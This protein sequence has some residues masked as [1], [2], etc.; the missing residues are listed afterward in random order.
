MKHVTP[1]FIAFLLAG[2]AGS[3]VTD[4]AQT[5]TTQPA[6]SIAAPAAAQP[7]PAAEATGTPAPV[8][9]AGPALAV[10]E[11]A[12]VRFKLHQLLEFKPEGDVISKPDPSKK[13]VMTDISC[14]NIGTRNV[15]PAEYMLSAYLV[16]NK[17]NKHSLPLSVKTVALFDGNPANKY[18]QEQSQGFYRDNF[19]PGEKARG[20]LYGV[21]VDKDVTLT[22]LVMEARDLKASVDLK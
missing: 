18:T 8:S 19:G 21:E 20:F 11:N 17:G 7:P 22:K 16:D 13:Y 6:D 14:E 2:L 12:D 1:L 9:T 3:C 15:Y 10:L 5:S 4:Q